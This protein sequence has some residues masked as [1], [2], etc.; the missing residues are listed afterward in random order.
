MRFVTLT[1]KF[2]YFRNFLIILI[3]K[4]FFVI[5]AVQQMSS[6]QKKACDKKLH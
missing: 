6:A 3:E 4:I 1:A 2:T 5:R